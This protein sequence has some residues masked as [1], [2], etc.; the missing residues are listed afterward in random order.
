MAEI[1]RII[2]TTLS[3]FFGFMVTLPVAVLNEYR[4]TPWAFWQLVLLFL[5]VAV[6]VMG[7]QLLQEKTYHSQE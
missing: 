4:G 7:L 5:G 3:L 1:A 6:L 2:Q